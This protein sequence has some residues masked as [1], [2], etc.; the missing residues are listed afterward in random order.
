MKKYVTSELIGALGNQL[1]NW[2]VGYSI[3]KNNNWNHFIDKSKVSKFGFFLEELGIQCQELSR[4]N[5]GIISHEWLNKKTA[6]KEMQIIKKLILDF[7]IKG[8]VYSEKKFHFDKAVLLVNPNTT[9]R[10]YFQSWKYFESNIEH[11]KTILSNGKKLN[12]SYLK[13]LQ[14]IDSANWVAIHVRRGDYLESWRNHGITTEKYYKKAINII[15]SIHLT[16]KKIVFSDDVN[17]AKEVVPNANIYISPIDIPNPAV[18]M[19]LMSSASAFIGANST[20]SWWSAFQLENEA[21]VIFPRPWFDDRNVNTD[22][23]LL[24]NWLTVGL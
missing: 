23:L 18:N 20:Y 4:S 3:A 16:D 9:L 2:A 22:D 12:T 24:P 8:K 1:F 11:I 17:L 6:R 21:P 7:E 15:D 10:G 13:Y 14:S 5:E 19:M